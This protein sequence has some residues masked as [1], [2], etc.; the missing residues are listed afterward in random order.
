M[1]RNGLVYVVLFLMLLVTLAACQSSASVPTPEPEAEQVSDV[2][3][4]FA[5]KRVLF[6]NSYHAGYEWSDDI[7]AG[8]KDVLEGTGA[9]LKI[10]RMDTK[11]NPGDEFGQNAA[12][13]V[14]AE[15]E[16]FAPDV[17]IAADDNA[18]KYLIVPYVMDT[19]VPVVFVGVNWDA[20][21]YGYPTDTVTGMVEVELPVQ[22]VEQLKGYA[23]GDKLAYLTVEANTET[24]ITDIYN[25]RF[26]DG[27]MEVYSVKTFAE[28]QEK[29]L[30]LQDTVDILLIGN[31]A[32]IDRWDEAEAEAFIVANSKIP[33]GT[34]NPWMAPYV[35]ISLAKIPNEQGEWAG[36]T[37]LDILNG[38]SAGDI[39]IVQ[40]REG[41]L[42][43]N[44]TIA[45]QLDISF[46]PAMLRNAE[47]YSSE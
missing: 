13:E 35:L 40:N 39:P 19:D 11:Q 27:E 38:T 42:I 1:K 10:V 12:L 36:Q 28:F 14:R 34:A 47:I 29:F 7:E 31:N 37:T 30:E 26:F 9:E 2:A 41:K 20:S 21:S 15:I 17:I 44:L 33:T 23:A 46:P 18:Q 22:L 8:L 5:G 3:A 4:D 32:G 45:E 43:L 25:E 24:K 6:V 16:A